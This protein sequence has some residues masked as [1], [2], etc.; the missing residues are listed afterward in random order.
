MRTL[1]LIGFAIIAIVMSVNFA[2]CGDDDDDFNSADL[3]GLWEGVTSEYYEKVNGEIID[4]ETE[5]L[6]DTRMKFNS[7]GTITAYSKNNGT[8]VVEEVTPTWQ[9]K[10]GKLYT[11]SE[12]GEPLIAT[13]LELNSER[14]VLELIESGTEDGQKWECYD[15]STYRKVTE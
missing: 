15:K 14:L 8:W 10:D 3:V 11:Q 7:D 12:D 1:R 13:I 2:A 9:I 4:E 5:N 6:D